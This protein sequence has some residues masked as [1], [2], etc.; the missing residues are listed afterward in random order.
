MNRNFGSLNKA[1]TDLKKLL[2]M[3]LV[4]SDQWSKTMLLP[5]VFLHVATTSMD[6]A[7][8]LLLAE[9]LTTTTTTTNTS[10][11]YARSKWWWILPCLPL[12]SEFLPSWLLYLYSLYRVS[13]YLPRQNTD[14]LESMFSFN[15]QWMR[16]DLHFDLLTIRVVMLLNYS[17]RRYRTSDSLGR[18]WVPDGKAWL[19]LLE[20]PILVGD[21]GYLFVPVLTYWGVPWT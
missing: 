6:L 13:A 15:A 10:I 21:L 16:S 19:M 2:A 5:Q 11:I 9:W 14:Q 3:A 8:F 4:R 1:T 20:L 17:K 18:H 12:A 7:C